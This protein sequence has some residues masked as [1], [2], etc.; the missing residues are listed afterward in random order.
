MAD[1]A[2][3]KLPQFLSALFSPWLVAFVIFVIII[4]L[5]WKHIS[6]ALRDLGS[7]LIFLWVEFRC[8]RFNHISKKWHEEWGHQLL[9][10]PLLIYEKA[11]L[12]QFQN[13][14]D[15][16][17]G[18]CIYLNGSQC[19]IDYYPQYYRDARLRA[20]ARL[21]ALQAS[22]TLSE[23]AIAAGF[24]KKNWQLIAELTS[25]TDFYRRLSPADRVSLESL[26]KQLIKSSRQKKR[27][28]NLTKHYKNYKSG[29]S[30]SRLV[31][32]LMKELK[33]DI[34]LEE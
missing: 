30:D 17:R 19:V 3:G 29:L 1:L 14:D 23:P 27:F 18:Y 25:L 11:H 24:D 26:T 12:G 4:L 7:W 20:Q 13:S 2:F 22:A 21:N 33:L 32:I 15:R 31:W 5:L 16:T 28:K 9:Y 6:K 8:R 34:D 10:I